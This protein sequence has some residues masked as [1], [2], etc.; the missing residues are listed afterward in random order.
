[1]KGINNGG[2]MLSQK[3]INSCKQILVRNTCRVTF[4]GYDCGLRNINDNQYHPES[5]SYIAWEYGFRR[6]RSDAKHTA[7]RMEDK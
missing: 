2:P 5:E 3:T 4:E 6:G 7:K 1:L